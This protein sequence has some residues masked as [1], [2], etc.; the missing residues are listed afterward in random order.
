MEIFLL[1]YLFFNWFQLVFTVS[2]LGEIL[3]F[4]RNF[5]N[6]FQRVDIAIRKV[7]LNVWVTQYINLLMKKMFW[8]R[9]FSWSFISIHLSLSVYINQFQ[10]K[11][12]TVIRKLERILI[13]LYRQ[14]VS[15]LFNQICLNE[16]LLPT[17]HT[18]THTHI[19]TYACMCAC[20]CV[21][22]WWRHLST[23]FFIHFGRSTF[24]ISSGWSTGWFV[25]LEWLNSWFIC[26][27]WYC[28]CQILFQMHIFIFIYI[29]NRYTIMYFF[30]L[31]TSL[32]VCVC[33]RNSIPN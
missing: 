31:S 8:F 28:D 29:L 18:H 33:V 15:L 4:F 21:C 22:V 32:C 26:L 27:Y 1:C 24:Q 16:R 5:K 9:C 7:T 19:Y 23:E 17:T 3:F 30:L 10:P 20:V 25:Y 12:K 6:S 11:T 14:N 2:S 13:K